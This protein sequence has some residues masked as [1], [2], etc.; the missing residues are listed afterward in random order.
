MRNDCGFE[1]TDSP[2]EVAFRMGNVLR[3]EKGNASKIPVR[4]AVKPGALSAEA[5]IGRTAPPV[6]GLDGRAA[7]AG[8]L[9]AHKPATC[10]GT[11][12]IQLLVYSRPL[13]DWR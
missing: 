13:P 8:V 3:G 5:C 10:P 7:L 1:C 6:T 2:A 11:V 12:K 9:A 4:P